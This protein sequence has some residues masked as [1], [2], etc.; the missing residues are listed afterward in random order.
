MRALDRWSVRVGG[1]LSRRALLRG[2]GAAV[3]LPWLEAFAPR[4]GA[5]RRPVRMAFLFMPNGVLPAAWRPVDEGPG[6]RLS[7][8]LEPLAPIRDEVLVL[9]G[10]HH[11]NSHEGEGHYVKTTALLSGARVRRT[12]GR[13][14]RCGISVDQLAARRLGGATWLPSLELGIEPPRQIVDMGYSTV[15]GATI[16]WRD[17]ELPAVKETRPRLAFERLFRTA[18]LG[19][20]A[21]AGVLDLVLE[22]ARGLRRALGAADRGKLDE[23]LDAVRALE[24][25]IG[26][27]DARRHERVEALLGGREV[28]AEPADFVEHVRLMFEVIE[29]AFR[30]DA[31]RIVTFMYGNAV[32][33]RDFSF[34]DRVEGGHHHLSHHEDDPVKQDQYARINRW[35]VASFAEFCARLRAIPDGEDSDLLAGSMVFFGSGIGDG[36]RHDPNELPILLAGRAGGRLRSG[37]HLRFPR[38]TPLCNLYLSML[39]A[40]GCPVGSFSDSTTPLPIQA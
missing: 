40:F 30:S 32:S 13:D 23:Y 25:R 16:S 21:E 34:V 5:G 39:D 15:Y 33:D 14:L 27:F 22:D 7:P 10:L 20:P 4:R 3:A 8:T 6:Y 35:F 17:A 31:T 26:R 36:N 24:Q 11:A 18:R 2:A 28:V 9:S 12:G 1:G 37:A 29:L 19:D 38:H